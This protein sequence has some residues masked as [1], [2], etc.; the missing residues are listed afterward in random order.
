MPLPTP[1][2]RQKEVLCLPE[3]GHYVVLGTAGSGKTTLAIHRAAYLANRLKSK[4]KVL[5]VTF[6]KSLVTYLNSLTENNLYKV[7]VRNYHWFARGYLDHR[8][9]LGWGDIVPSM[10]YN[11][12]N[13]KL[14]FIKQA[15]SEVTDVYCKNST[16][17]RAPEVFYEEI[18]WIQ[19]MGISS[20]D[21]YID[22]ERIGRSGTRI[23]RD[24]RKYFFTVYE[25]YLDIR[26]RNDYRF[27]WDDLAHTVKSELENDNDD[28]MY[29]HI[30]IDE[31]QDLSPVMLQSLALAVPEDGSIT[32]FGDVAQQIYGGRISWRNAGLNVT[33]NEIWKFDQNYRN[34]KEIADLAIAISKQPFFKQSADLVTPKEPVASG[35][36]PVLAEFHNENTELKWVV[37]NAAKLGEGQT[38]AILMRTRQSLK[39]LRNLLKE[40]RVFP[41]ELDGDLKRWNSKPGV[42]I[43]T[44]HS[45]KGLEFDAVMIPYCSADRLPD[46]DKI[47]ALE[48]RDEALGEESKLIYVAVTRARRLLAMS[49]TGQ[50]T[51]IIPQDDSLYLKREIEK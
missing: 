47:T 15:I 45:A 37:R 25:R 35:P 33:K 4:E 48:D 3:K 29:K 38:V 46:E 2:G 43:G 5:L 39:K 22:A 44:Y 30:I 17:S 27:D 7:D 36:K 32:F 9:M 40:Q 24:K 26:E 31:G 23:T 16:L 6:N 11:K 8:G 50:V 21:E 20:L 18:S 10:D 41:Q 49:Y 12:E 14:T 51:E 42:S 1:E 19:K 34:S 13:K 28:K